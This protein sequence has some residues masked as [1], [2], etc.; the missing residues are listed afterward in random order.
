MKSSNS[1]NEQGVVTVKVEPRNGF[2]D[3]GS[4][5]GGRQV[6]VDQAGRVDRAD[7]ALAGHNTIDVHASDARWMKGCGL[8][9][10][11]LSFTPLTLPDPALAVVYAG[12]TFVGAGGTGPYVFEVSDGVLPPGLAM[13]TAGVITGTP[14]AAGDFSFAVQVT[15][16]TGKTGVNN[17]RVTV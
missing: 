6:N 14:T 9:S 12:A 8:V 5:Y 17:Y 4:A 11:V 1:V 3:V 15:D 7:S 16:A 10:Q 13:S 2:G